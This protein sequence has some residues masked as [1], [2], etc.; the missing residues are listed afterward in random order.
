MDGADL[1]FV[2]MEQGEHGEAYMSRGL[3]TDDIST[4]FL[5]LCQGYITFQ[6][7]GDIVSISLFHYVQ[8]SYFLL[9]YT[10]MS[11][12]NRLSATVCHENNSHVYVANKTDNDGVVLTKAI[13]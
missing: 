5:T 7:P 6:T 3:V 12:N 4:F 2:E 11:T 8:C 10:Y 9:M 1:R 13:R